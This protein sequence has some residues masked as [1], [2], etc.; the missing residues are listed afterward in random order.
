MKKKVFFIFLIFFAVSTTAIDFFHTETDFEINEIDCP[1]CIFKQSFSFS[2]NIT[3]II[4]I[5]T[6]IFLFLLKGRSDFLNLK[7]VTFSIKNNIDED[8]SRRKI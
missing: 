7:F 1:V 2:P 5:F 3:T 4:L 6:I 8:L